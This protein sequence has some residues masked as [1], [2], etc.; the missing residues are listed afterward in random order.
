M[1]VCFGCFDTCSKH[2]N[3]PKKIFFGFVKQTETQPKQTEFWFFLVQ[4]ENI[5]FL[6]RGHPTRGRASATVF[7]PEHINCGDYK[8]ILAKTVFDKKYDENYKT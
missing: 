4:T 6:F 2:R 7:V 3:K 1:H 5:F 8:E